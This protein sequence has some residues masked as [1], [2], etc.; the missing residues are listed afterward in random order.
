[1]EKIIINGIEIDPQYY[2]DKWT[3]WA[4][5]AT[6]ATDEQV[7]SNVKTLYKKANLQEPNVLVFRDYE[8]FI[9]YQW[10]S[11]GDSVWNSVGDS[12]WNSVGVS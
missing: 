8:K 1:M 7:I 10:A 9:N 2:I 5:E 6:P 4:L 3:K 12:V 11:V